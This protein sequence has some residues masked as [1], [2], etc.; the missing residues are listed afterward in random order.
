[1]KFPETYSTFPAAQSTCPLPISTP[2]V[3]AAS[4]RGCQS[5][6]G[7]ALSALV[8]ALHDTDC[9]EGAVP[10]ADAQAVVD[11]AKSIAFA[12]DEWGRELSDIRAEVLDELVRRVVLDGDGD[13]VV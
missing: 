3:L 2:A 12:H 4:I 5:N 8:H 9:F 1:M 11:A 7:L 10:L 6:P 13:L